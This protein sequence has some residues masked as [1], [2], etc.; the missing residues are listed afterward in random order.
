MEDLK[1]EERD[2]G[3]ELDSN[4]Q[5]HFDRVAVIEDSDS[6]LFQP[7]SK[8][9]SLLVSLLYSLTQ[10]RDVGLFGNCFQKTVSTPF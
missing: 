4:L 3:I 9:E 1:I 8:S 10:S 5:A 6:D 7:Q 2:M